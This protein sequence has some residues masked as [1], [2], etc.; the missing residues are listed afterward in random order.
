MYIYIYTI[1]NFIYFLFDVIIIKTKM[2]VFIA[3]SVD[4]LQLLGIK[5]E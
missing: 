4:I 5:Q 3:L 1:F 2:Y